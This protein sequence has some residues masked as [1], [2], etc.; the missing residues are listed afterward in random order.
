MLFTQISINHDIQEFSPT[1]KIWQ[2][3]KSNF[4]ITGS[5]TLFH[6]NL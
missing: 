3:Q 1:V 2:V 6:K 4:T 5:S